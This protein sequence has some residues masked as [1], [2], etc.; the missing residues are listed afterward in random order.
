M[1]MLKQKYVK[2]MYKSVVT[3]ANSHPWEQ[4]T[5]TFKMIISMVNALPPQKNAGY[6]GTILAKIKTRGP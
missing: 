6:L 3:T 1:I 2:L 4:Q 5:L